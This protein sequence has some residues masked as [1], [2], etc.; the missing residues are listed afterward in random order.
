MKVAVGLVVL[1]GIVGCARPAAR[2][3][4]TTLAASPAAVASDSSPGDN[5][6][7]YRS[8]L[9][10]PDAGIRIAAARI[11]VGHGNQTARALL[12]GALRSP[13]AHHRID[14]A[15]ALQGVADEETV[16]ALRQAADQEQQPLARAVLKQVLERSSR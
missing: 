8:L 6:S 9:S 16:H 4:L 10:D 3:S 1:A 2:S 7:R 5:L 13:D 14:A 11:L 15:L 12:M